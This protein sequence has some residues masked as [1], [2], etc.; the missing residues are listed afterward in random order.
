MVTEPVVPGGRLVARLDVPAGVAGATTIHAE[1]RCMKVEWVEAR[2]KRS[3]AE[4]AVWN[5]HELK[6]PRDAVVGARIL[7]DNEVGSQFRGGWAFQMEANGV[8]CCRFVPAGRWLCPL[9]KVAAR[10]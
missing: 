9:S 3:I 5:V 10:V 6:T 1:L 7:P 2:G 8:K 4:N